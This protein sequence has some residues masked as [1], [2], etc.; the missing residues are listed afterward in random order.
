M[1]SELQPYVGAEFQALPLD[2]IIA[3]PLTA[4]V[5]AQAVVAAATCDLIKTMLDKEGVP[6]SV[7]F[8]IEAK[9]ADNKSRSVK[10]NVPMLS[11][12][13]VPHLRIDSLTVHF[14]Y[15]ITQSLRRS[16]QAEKNASVQLKTGAGLSLWAEATLQGSVSSKSSEESSTNRSGQLEIT[17]HASEAPMPEG[18][19]RILNLLAKTVEVPTA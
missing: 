3:A 11:L 8:Q 16:E 12:V 14:K 10:I 5:K 7:P 9:D 19:A 6:V 15:E 17:L 4:A 18:L 1:A 13:P 2:F